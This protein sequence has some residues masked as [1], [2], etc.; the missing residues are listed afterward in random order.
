MARMRTKKW[1]MPWIEEHGDLIFQDPSPLKGKWKEKLHSQKLHLEIG[2]GK[3]AYLN[4]MA[5]LYPND[6]WVGIEKEVAAI[7]MAARYSYEENPNSFNNK[8]FVLGDADQVLNWFE[9]KEIHSLHLNFSD[10]WPKKYTHKRRLSSQKF[11]ERYQ[12]I[13]ED[14]GE[15]IMKTDNKGLFEDSLVY[16]NESGFLLKEVSV[17][18]RRNQH[19]E[20]AITEY[21]QRFM[22][23]GQ[24][25]Y[26]CIVQKNKLE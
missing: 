13:L 7:A 21:E 17:D 5:T 19:P 8:V 26:H 20:D 4:Q 11:L 24:P 12:V 14:D 9:A 10:P 3:G 6:A 15:I 25:I 1:A 2:S 18:Y 22:D 16:F 23:L